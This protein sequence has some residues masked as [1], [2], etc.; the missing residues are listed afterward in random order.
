MIG[1]GLEDL[2]C[3]EACGLPLMWRAPAERW[4]TRTLGKRVV[5]D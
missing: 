3:A 5:T 1:V 4:H 2:L